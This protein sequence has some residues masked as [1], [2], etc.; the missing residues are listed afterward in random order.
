MFRSIWWCLYIIFYSTFGNKIELKNLSCS[1][2]NKRIVN[3][4]VCEGWKEKFWMEVILSKPVSDFNV[5]QYKNFNSQ[6][7]EWE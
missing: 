3:I 4:T 7:R 2:E 6:T 1:T 5:C